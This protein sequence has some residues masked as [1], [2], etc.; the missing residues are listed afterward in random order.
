M[1]PKLKYFLDR[2]FTPLKWHEDNI[3]I[4]LHV[5][6]RRSTSNTVVF[7]TV[8]DLEKKRNCR[9]LHILVYNFFKNNRQ[10]TSSADLSFK[11]T[12]DTEVYLWDE[13]AFILHGK[14]SRRKKRQSNREC[15]SDEQE[16]RERYAQQR[17]K[18]RQHMGFLQARR[19]SL[20]ESML[21][22]GLTDASDEKDFKLAQR[23]V[24][25]KWHPDKMIFRS[26]DLSEDDFL[27][28]SKKY[29]DAVAEV[30]DYL[31]V[32]WDSVK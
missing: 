24:L 18:Y 23:N 9:M 22:L 13:E 17:K 10:C 21:V 8:T 29:T 3:K 14:E 4:G 11:K 30:K 26:S 5:V 2:Q 12:K 20:Q 31:S 25:L 32:I 15:G 27:K 28:L 19:T 7:G 1:H 6:L 16:I